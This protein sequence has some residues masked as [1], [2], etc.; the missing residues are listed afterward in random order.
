MAVKRSAKPATI[1]AEELERRFPNLANLRRLDREEHIK[2]AM[3]MGLTRQQAEAHVDAEHEG[4]VDL[5]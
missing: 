2:R 1:D 4:E 3:A 5:D